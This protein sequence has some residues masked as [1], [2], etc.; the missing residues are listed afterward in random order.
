VLALA[1]LVGCG[2]G[3]DDAAAGAS[4]QESGVNA[5]EFGAF[6]GEC[7][8]IDTAAVVQV[9]G[10]SGLELVANNGIKCRWETPTGSPYVMFTWFRGSP[11]EREREVAIRSGK[12]VE[13]IEIDG[14]RAFT[15]AADG[16]CQVGIADGADFIHWLVRTDTTGV[17]AASCD[18]AIGL[19][20]KTIGA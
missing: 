15:S 12:I 14:H 7:G 17:A 4:V 6:Y 9:T 16:I 18:T 10:Y 13:D 1:F 11:F 2:G 5:T 19:G 20:A 3:G 8:S